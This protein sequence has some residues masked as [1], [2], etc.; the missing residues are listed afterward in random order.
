MPIRTNRRSFLAMLTL[1]SSTVL[2]AACGQQAPAA[3]PK[4]GDAPKPATDTKPAAPTAAPAKPAAD[5]KPAESKPAAEAKPTQAAPAA[6]TSAPT[7]KATIAQG[8]DPRSLW[9]SSST[10]QQEINVS[11]QVNEKLIEFNVEANDVEPR[12]ATEWRQVDDTTLQMKLR[13]NVTFTNGEPFNAESA[14]FS[15]E[16]MIKAPAYASF[17]SVIAGADVVDP[18]TINVKTKAPTLLHIPALA[19]GSFQYPAKYFQEVGQD[20]FGRK[21]VGTGPYT[22]AEWVKDSHV[23]LEANPQYWNGAPAVKTV[24]FRNIPEGAAKLAALEAGEV[25]LIIDVP[26]DAIERVER[27]SALQMFSRPSNRT[28]NLTMSTLTDTP[29]KKA[30][31]RQAMRH[32]IDVPA[33]IRGLFKG[34]A[35]QMDG[36]PL[37]KSFFGYDPSRQPFAYDPDKAKQ[38]FAA[39]GHPDGFEVTFKYT[40]GRYA[41]DK[42]TG[43]AIAAQLQRVGVRTKQEV[44]ESGAFLTQLSTLQLN[45]MFFSGSLPPPDAH[46][47]FQTYQTGFRYSYYSNKEL[48]ALIERGAS[49]A[50]RDERT[51]I[52][53]QALDIIDKD[54]PGVPLFAPDDV[55]AGGKKLGGFT[56]RGSQ[57][58][59]VRSFTLS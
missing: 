52:Y 13:P 35:R 49:T 4:A 9:A 27:N 7:G 46:F 15:I 51:R 36:Q 40:S 22:F 34:R 16:T 14:K 8:I 25:D 54:P 37:G 47:T 28:F 56:P 24:V 59:D 45:D 10:A 55:Y 17:T 44:L 58:I 18:L 41:Q 11:E 30:E 2:L 20:A 33:L 21:P 50:N 31:V 23:A 5:A 29:L 48:D 3:A 6:K 32:A 38:M 53:L 26:L 42:E 19:M 1:G 12:L 43:Q 57:F 39:A